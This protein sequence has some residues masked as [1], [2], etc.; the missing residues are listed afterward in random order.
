MYKHQLVNIEHQY[1][2]KSLVRAVSSVDGSYFNRYIKCVLKMN[3]GIS[4]HRHT[5]GVRWPLNITFYTSQD[6]GPTIWKCTNIIEAICSFNEKIINI[7]K[8]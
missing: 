4:T 2:V 3:V 8:W 5:E 6:S 7:I 1:N